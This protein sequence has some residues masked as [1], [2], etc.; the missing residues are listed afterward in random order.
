MSNG[1]D[2]MTNCTSKASSIKSAGY[3]FVCRYYNT[4]NTSKNLTLA[5]AKALSNAGLY[6]VPIW[7]N[8]Y[9]TSASYFSKSKGL[10]DGAAAYAY[11]KNIIGQPG[12][13]V[14]YFAVDYDAS[15]ADI[16]GVI[17]DYFNGVCEAFKSAGGNYGIGVYGSGAVCEYICRTVVQVGYTWLAQSTGW[18]G[19]GKYKNWNIKQGV[20]CIVAGVSCDSDISNDNA[21]GFKIS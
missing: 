6:I 5:E 4:N 1:L 3:D 14:I 8:G 16:S 15:T 19:Y 10:S 13:S 18:A 21:G 17:T 7:E 2:T 9:P 12:L 11:A 20:S